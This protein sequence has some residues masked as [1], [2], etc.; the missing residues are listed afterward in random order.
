MSNLGAY[1]MVTTGIKALGGPAK[2]GLIAVGSVVALTGSVYR[3]GVNRGVNM[4]DRQTIEAKVTEWVRSRFAQFN[5]HELSEVYTVSADVECGGGLMLSAGDR[6]RVGKVIDDMVYI[7]VEGSDDN[8]FIVSVE[9][10]G[11]HSDYPAPIE[12]EIDLPTHD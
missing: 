7:E 9:Q 10:L 2:A 12:K 11:Q 1:Q 5:A 3:F 4:G 8:P 6:F